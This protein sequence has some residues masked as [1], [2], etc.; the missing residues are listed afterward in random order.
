MKESISIKDLNSRIDKLFEESSKDSQI[1]SLSAQKNE[2]ITKD[3]IDKIVS[4]LSNTIN[5]ASKFYSEAKLVTNYQATT[6][7]N[8]TFLDKGLLFSGKDAYS[9]AVKVSEELQ[10]AMKPYEFEEDIGGALPY[11]LLDKKH[12][13][14]VTFGSSVDW[15]ALGAV[16][17]F[18]ILKSNL[19]LL[20]GLEKNED[21]KNPKTH[22]E[23]KPGE[24]YEVE[25]TLYQIADRQPIDNEIQAFRVLSDYSVG[26]GVHVLHKSLFKP[27]KFK[28]VDKRDKIT[29]IIK[30]KE[31]QIAKLKQEIDT[32]KKLIMKSENKAKFSEN[33]INDKLQKGDDVKVF[34]RHGKVVK[35][36]G[37]VV[38]IE[39][40]ADD[41]NMAR[42]DSYYKQDVQKV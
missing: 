5:K 4:I 3:N 32:L 11:M 22:D 21:F 6:G 30:E 31:A 26:S 18:H 34:G 19:R 35:I 36:R 23:I 2:A 40:P 29:K 42:S 9:K 20:E 7:S 17:G 10:K 14:I 24:W 13:V 1:I 41:Q 38:D 25:G 16:V 39:F 33:I 28:F 15:G 8:G 12:H 27:D 37:D